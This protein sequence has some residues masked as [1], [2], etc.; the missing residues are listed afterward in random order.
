VREQM[1]A[2]EFLRHFSQRLFINVL[3]L[4]LAKFLGEG[5]ET[6]K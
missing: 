6:F 4:E 5:L 2:S 1:S 3:L